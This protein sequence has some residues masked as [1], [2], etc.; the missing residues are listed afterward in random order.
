MNVKSIHCRMTAWYAGLL[1]C[2]LAL[3]RASVYFGLRA[4]WNGRSARRCPNGRARAV[5]I[6]F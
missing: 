4:T 5:K 3:F 1:V 2:L 6:I